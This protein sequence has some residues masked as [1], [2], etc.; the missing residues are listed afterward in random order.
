VKNVPEPKVK[1][2]IDALVQNYNP[3]RFIIRVVS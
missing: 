2:V 1:D 3:D